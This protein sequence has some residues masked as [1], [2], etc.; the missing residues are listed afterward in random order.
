MMLAEI[1][2]GDLLWTTIVV[3]FMISYFMLLFAVLSDVFRDRELG[4]VS[5]AIWIVLLLA[6]PLVTALVY[7]ISRGD[8]MA[9]RSA[10]AA[11]DA[12]SEFAEYVQSVSGRSPAGEI[13]RAKELLDA[14][15][16][17]QAEFARLK[18]KAL[19]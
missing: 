10:K 4:G 17:D 15:V 19:G 14:G 16:I 13:A 18:A 2:L 5:K 7:L 1:G 6:F 12:E 8:G 3:F 9:R 11:T